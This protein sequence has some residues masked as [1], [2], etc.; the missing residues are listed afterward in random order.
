MHQKTIWNR[1]RSDLSILTEQGDPDVFLWEHAERV[2]RNAEMIAGLPE[3]A[4]S[5]PDGAA[6]L[7]AAL[8]HEA[9][10]VARVAAGEATRLD[11]L[12][13]GIPDAYRE[14]GAGIMERGLSGHLSADSIKR[15]SAAIRTLHDRQIDSVEGRIVTDAD[16]LEEFG[17]ISLWTTIRRGMLD[18]KGVQSVIETWTRRKEYRF[19][20]ARLQD[21]FHFDAVRRMAEARL[22]NMEQFMQSL[23]DEQTGSVSAK[24]N[25]SKAG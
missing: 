24:A 5:S 3:V 7:A 13:R 11:V 9:G 16:N 18:G 23:S 15:A 1:A 12:V 19:W 4:K 22:E 2:A 25:A 10:W 14:Q 6:V 20:E 21:S 17:L 8:Y